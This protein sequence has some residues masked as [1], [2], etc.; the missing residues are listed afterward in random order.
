VSTSIVQRLISK[1][2]YLLRKPVLGYVG[3]GIVSLM[4]LQ[5]G[6]A[7]AFNFGSILIITVLIA[8]G[9]HVVMATVVGERIEQTL[10]FVMSLPISIAQY[11]L[12]KILAN[13]TLFVGGWLIISLGVCGVILFREGVPH[14]LIMLSTIMLMYLLASYFVL[15]AVAVTTESMGATIATVIASNILL[16]M[17][18]YAL[19]NVPSIKSTYGSDRVIWNAAG[20]EVISVEAA[21][22]LLALA[23]TF[24]FQ[25]RKTDFL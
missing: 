14:G 8:L 7:A 9:M 18:M 17:L 5:F 24:I 22:I 20:L 21:V 25:A 4:L 2:W 10:P 19:S 3:G 12:A 13:A 11:T 15:L 23:L 6:G 16:N 1:D